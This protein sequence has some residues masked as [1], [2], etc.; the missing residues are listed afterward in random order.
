M[1]SKMFR[2]ILRYYRFIS[3]VLTDAYYYFY[4]STLRIRKRNNENLSAKIIAHVHSIERAFSLKNPRKEFGI[5]LVKNLKKLIAKISDE[6]KY[7]YE[8]KIFHSAIA[9]YNKYHKIQSEITSCIK[10]YKLYSHTEFSRSTSYLN[11]VSKRHSIRN[12]STEKINNRD[13]L[14]A[15]VIAKNITPSVCNR[16]GW[17]VILVKNPILVRKVLELQNGN[18]GIENIQYVLVLCSILT[19]FFDSNERNQPYIDGGIFLMSLLNSLHYK[20]IA[21]CT[22][23]WAVNKNQD[24]KLKELLDINNS[25][26]II[27]LVG[28][29]SYPKENI[30][31]ASSYRK[32]LKKILR[33]ME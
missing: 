33:I 19:S 7:K 17:E 5:E 11:V 2:L 15:I 6:E 8:M 10:P 20:N 3:D 24:F 32:P 30:K 29:G 13:L 31:V 9:E 27:A 4:Y 18:A 22:L 25:K 23:N 16:Q 12:F 28:I 14:N 21:S 1:I 26:V